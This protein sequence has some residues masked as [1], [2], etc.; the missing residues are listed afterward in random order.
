[1]RIK[2]DKN[3]QVVADRAGKDVNDM[4]YVMANALMIA[5]LIKDDEE[6]YGCSVLD[7]N[8][9][10]PV[11]TIIDVMHE[12]G[13]ENVNDTTYDA[14]AACIIIGDGDCPECGGT[15]ELWD[16][17][18][19]EVSSGDRDLPPDYVTE[20]E[21]WRCPICGHIIERDYINS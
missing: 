4:S 10:T 19:Y 6:Y 8:G 16:C 12:I 3:L 9:D 14:F 17:E 5:G 1:M 2:I 11:L 20:C 7:C 15:M 13:V 21:K 18:G